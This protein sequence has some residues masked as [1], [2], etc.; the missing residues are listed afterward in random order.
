MYSFET[1]IQG[2]SYRL[3]LNEVS[4]NVKCIW[5]SNDILRPRIINTEKNPLL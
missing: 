4:M 3:Y 1:P 2:D 5:Y